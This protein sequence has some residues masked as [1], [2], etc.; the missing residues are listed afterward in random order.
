VVL[1][2]VLAAPAAAYSYFPGEPDACFS[3]GSTTFR[4]ASA[5]ADADYRV[6]FAEPQTHA[7]LRIQLMDSPE[8]AD[9]VL[10]DDIGGTSACRGAAAVKTV[11]I[12][13]EATAPDVTVRLGADLAAADYRIYVH[14]ARFSA[15]DAAALLA[16]ISKMQARY[17]LVG[18]AAF[19]ADVATGPAPDTRSSEDRADN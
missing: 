18:V 16:V 5:G 4:M 14:S 10:V 1:A 12:D 13:A 15:R 19:P 2:A 7:D 3:S 6:R 11:R 9:F 8:Q 17:H